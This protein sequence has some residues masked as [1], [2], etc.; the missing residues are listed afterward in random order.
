MFAIF[1]TFPEG[2]QMEGWVI[3]LLHCPGLWQKSEGMV[4]KKKENKHPTNP[5]NKRH[6]II[7]PFVSRVYNI[8]KQSF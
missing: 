5:E 6:L 7:L 2:L 4:G 1:R 8:E 3:F